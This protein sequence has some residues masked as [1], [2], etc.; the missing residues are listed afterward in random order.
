MFW[1]T[2]LPSTN[3]VRNKIEML[4][5]IG[6]RNHLYI[7]VYIGALLLFFGT[8][9]STLANWK[10]WQFTN[11]HLA[12]KGN[13]LDPCFCGRPSNFKTYINMKVKCNATAAVAVS[14]HRIQRS[15]DTFG[16]ANWKC[17][18]LSS[19]NFLSVRVYLF[20][21]STHYALTQSRTQTPR[22]A[23]HAAHTNVSN[24]KI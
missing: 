2:N 4:A 15:I 21:L 12:H 17:S 13:L 7:Q 20:V 16:F 6:D 10:F 19:V 9:L 5:F 11:G 22:N 18:M 23:A 1:C 3:S 24:T 14:H 8:S